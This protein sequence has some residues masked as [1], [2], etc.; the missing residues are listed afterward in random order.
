MFSRYPTITL[1]A[2]LALLLC[3]DSVDAKDA[4]RNNK[5]AKS[6]GQQQRVLSQL[7]VIHVPNEHR[8]RRVQNEDDMIRID[9]VTGMDWPTASPTSLPTTV[10]PEGVTSDEPSD[11]ASDN[12]S[13][14]AITEEVPAESDPPT[15]VEIDSAD[16]TVPPTDPTRGVVSSSESGTSSAPPSN[17]FA[18]AQGTS[19][20]ASMV[21]ITIGFFL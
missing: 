10:D 17:M 1:I 4:L 20:I 2:V 15:E 19:I 14:I 16:A 8:Q 21:A 5:V 12:P 13:A 11:S 9:D 6:K 18:V 3:V 7:N